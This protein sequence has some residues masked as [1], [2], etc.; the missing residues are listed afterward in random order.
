MS[1]TVALPWPDDVPHLT[2]LERLA[3][4]RAFEYFMPP[5]CKNRHFY[6]S[7]NRFLRYR[8]YYFEFGARGLST[9]P[10][11]QQCI[12]LSKSYINYMDNH[13]GCVDER[14]F[15]TVLDP[16]IEIALQ[17]YAAIEKLYKYLRHNDQFLNKP[18]KLITYIMT[19]LNVLLEKNQD[20]VP[21]FNDFWLYGKGVHLIN[22][23]Y[24]CL[25]W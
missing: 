19:K 24:L 7:Y 10:E 3:V 9:I 1:V 20:R 17:D 5:H 22:T 23:A 6:Y 13:D 2:S 4:V 16:E 25:V 21:D 11:A 12:N 8:H 15:H 18:F 14:L